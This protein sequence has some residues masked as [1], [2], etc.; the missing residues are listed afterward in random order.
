MSTARP[1]RLKTEQVRRQDSERA[2]ANSVVRVWVDNSIAHLDSTFD[3]LVP[4]RLTDQIKVGVRVR[5]PFAGREVEGLVVNRLDSSEIAGLKFVDS[6]ISPFVVASAQL[7]ELIR[8]ACQAWISHPYDIVRSAI[9]PRVA[10][11]EK[12]LAGKDDI[13]VIQ[14]RKEPSSIEYLHLQ[15]HNEGL[16]QL[17][18]FA[19]KQRAS[20]SV[21]IILPEEREVERVEKLLLGVT[22]IV[23]SA[24]LAR[25]KR[26]ENYLLAMRS[27]NSIIIG[28][29]SAIFST[30]P[31]L[32]SII[33]YREVSHSHYEPRS[34]GWNTRDLA[35]I[36][37]RS[38]NL[39]LFFMGYSPS[40]EI[41][42]MIENEEIKF[43]G[44]RNKLS[45][46]TFNPN[47]GE[48]LPARIFPP[49]R[50]A[51]KSG[52]VLFL[53]P[54]KGYAS[55]LICSKCR[56]IASCTCGG[57]LIKKNLGSA[58]QCL[59]CDLTYSEWRC[60]WCQND[61]SF[62]AGRGALRHGEEIGR[63]FPNFPVINSDG[64]HYVDAIDGKA[65]LVIATS[66]MAPHNPVGYSA[67]VILEGDTFFSYADLRAQERS[68][69]SFFDAAAHLKAEGKV[70]ISIDS[71]HP[72]SASLTKWNP[73]IMATRELSD[74]AEVHLPPSSRAVILDV[75]QKEATT[76]VDGFK[77]AL[78]DLRIPASTRILGPSLK[79]NDDARIILTCNPSDMTHLAGFLH[80]YT[81]HRAASKKDP[82][83]L[84]VDPYSLSE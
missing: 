63:A 18:D 69:E 38:E 76:I 47:R 27:E 16:Q 21:L 71:G 51:L 26:Y 55:A 37:S 39:S 81:R 43:R 9:P 4:E 60:R 49:I 32:I 19:I 42:A 57:R 67:V 14:K 84:R 64:D 11:V 40:S 28:T 34:P 54:R 65:A 46:L 8:V 33:V 66:G 10:S 70:L 44:K 23:L 24:S 22:P 72:I 50:D 41:A 12:I 30:P 80:E 78:L 61:K 45:V 7:I 48:L 58:V 29:R 15:P 79:N 20:G 59:M 75:S 56:N 17:I 31:D 35:I 82:L 36:R 6:V 25:S 62:L 73:A 83:F 2:L 68:R 1:L 53:V 77:K 74:R 5:I 3:Y 52:A 13:S